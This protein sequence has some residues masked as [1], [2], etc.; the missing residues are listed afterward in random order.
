MAF[1]APLRERQKAIQDAFDESRSDPKA[2]NGGPVGA[3]AG[4]IRDFERWIGLD[5]DDTDLTSEA[6]SRVYTL[7]D[8]ARRSGKALSLDSKP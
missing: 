5:S 8:E 6:I 1:F 7:I 3:V 2:G 4:A